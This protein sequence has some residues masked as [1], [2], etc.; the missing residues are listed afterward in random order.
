M[1]RPR[2]AIPRLVQTLILT[3]PAVFVVLV[4]AQIS[5]PVAG[6]IY[7]ILF[8][9][10]TFVR[11]GTALMVMLATALFPY[12]V[13]IGLPV[14]TALGEISLILALPS[15]LHR[16]AA[17]G[18]TPRLPP[19]IIPT[20]LYFLICLASVGRGGV[21]ASVLVSTAQMILYL[22]V[23]VVFFSSF[24]DKPAMLRRALQAVLVSGLILGIATLVEQSGYVLGM[25]KNAVGA[26]LSF[27]TVIAVELWISE[28]ERK[29]KR[30]YAITMGIVAA[31]L[32]MS[33]SRGGWLGASGGITVIFLLRR[34]VKLLVRCLCILIP[35]LAACW[36]W[37]P[38]SA[39]EYALDIQTDAHSTQSRLDSIEYAMPYFYSSPIIGSGV[40][41]RKQYDATNV[42]VSTLA[43]TGALGLAAFIAIHLSFFWMVWKTTRRLRFDDPRFTF[44][45][46]G[47][48]LVLCQFIHGSFDHYWARTLLV[49]WGS[50]GMATYAYYSCRHVASA[51]NGRHAIE[52]GLTSNSRRSA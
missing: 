3:A 48:G 7:G 32:L 43:E 26:S 51:P 45:T 28:P 23:A 17:A 39:K 29:A 20:A 52:P 38:E 35:I 2:P 47:G 12:D 4:V 40:G 16:C 49:V 11:P 25:H 5:L 44:A 42:I 21:D 10:L 6:A 19:F 37:M 18:R 9:G 34:R 15:F 27:A 46:V 22:V 1:A 33:C 31:G 24:T 14:K 30:W 50:A 13:A 41:L 36:F 8:L